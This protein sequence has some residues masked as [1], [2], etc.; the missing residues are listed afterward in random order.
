MKLSLTHAQTQKM[1]VSG[2]NDA[3]ADQEALLAHLAGCAECRV[4]AALAAELT[5]EL[6]SIYA[7]SDLSR[8]EIRQKAAAVQPVLRRSIMKNKT[9][10]TLR[11]AVLAGGTLAVLIL[12]ILLWPKL[13]PEQFGSAPQSTATSS[14]IPTEAPIE[15]PIPAGSPSPEAVQDPNRPVSPDGQ[16]TAAFNPDT[17]RLE[18][19]D[20]QGQLVLA[21]PKDSG[22]SENWLI[23]GKWSP[24]SRYLTFWSGPNSAS[25]QADGISL[26]LLEIQSGEARQISEGAL[27]NRAYQSWSPDGKTLAFTD[28][29]YRSAQVGKQLLLVEADTGRISLLESSEKLV[30]GAVAWS[31][32]DNLIAVAAVAAEFT[33]P[34]FADYSGWDNP[35]IAA[36]RIYLVDPASGEY[37]LADP[38][39]DAYQDWPRF[40]R[41]GSRLYFVQHDG[42]TA[43][44]MVLDVGTSTLTP[45]P[46]C[47]TP[48]PPSAGYYGQMDWSQLYADCIQTAALDLVAESSPLPNAIS[49]PKPALTAAPPAVSEYASSNSF[50][51]SFY[52]DQGSY[53][54]FLVLN[55]NVKG[56]IPYD[57]T[58]IEYPYIYNLGTGTLFPVIPTLGGNNTVAPP[59]R[60]RSVS[61]NGRYLLYGLAANS[62]EPAFEHYNYIYLRDLHNGGDSKIDL[63][64]LEKDLKGSIYPSLSPD[65]RFL[66]LEVPENGWQ[67]Y[68][69][70]L[71]TERVTP[72]SVDVGNNWVPGSTSLEPVFSADGRYLAFVSDSAKLVDGDTA[73]SDANPACMD[74]FLYEITTG[75]LERIPAGIQFTMGNPYPYLTVSADARYLA[76]TELDSNPI[77]YRPVIR[78]HDRV[79]GNTREITAEWVVGAS[80]PPF[81]F[82]HSPS[83]SADGRWLAFGSLAAVNADGSPT[84][85]AYAQVYLIDL[86][87][88]DIDKALTLVSADHNGNPGNGPSGVVAL[89]QEG[90]SSDIHISPD[91]R[92]VAFSSRAVNLLPAGVQQRQCNDPIVV[93]AY[94]CYDLYI[95][96]RETGK[97]TYIGAN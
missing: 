64:P 10:H 61:A 17:L 58:G 88:K 14:A 69:Y 93:G 59:M 28:G 15:T 94:P 95:Y 53:T 20:A 73:C 96:D 85:D 33:G 67:L 77:V 34:D 18:V 84:P 76:W 65:G 27:V 1:L 90:W 13:L 60:A 29:A 55:S 7:T 71:A 80:G 70:E 49:S 83:I 38:A 48:L 87:E 32:S 50:G 36:R 4:Y 91:G 45:V 9:L 2:L 30:T 97:L 11:A 75:K 51:F 82:G 8:T 19:V 78:L 21:Y 43:R 3:H 25:I 66:A 89:Q 6:P 26:W 44:I 39:A 57:Q 42:V 47:E 54:T 37:Q 23:P 22:S 24:D 52:Y 62:T 16:Y 40:N 74:V 56:L 31:P 72:V 81:T 46:G 63:L 41:D 86:Q 79:T 35:A 92:F 5:A 12:L 68:L